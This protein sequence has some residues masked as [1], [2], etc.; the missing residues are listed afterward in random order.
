MHQARTQ[1]Y[2][3]PSTVYFASCLRPTCLFIHFSAWILSL[4][5]SF[6]AWLRF[7]S[8]T[9][10]SNLS[11]YAHTSNIVSFTAR[12][13][14]GCVNGVYIC[15]LFPSLLLSLFSKQLAKINKI[16]KTRA[17]FSKDICCI[18]GFV[19]LTSLINDN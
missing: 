6:G 9:S 7:W 18:F 12:D 2:F 19:F 4:P 13:R 3:V 11:W 17:L 16:K 8:S 1:T 15:L 5:R 14:H 10:F